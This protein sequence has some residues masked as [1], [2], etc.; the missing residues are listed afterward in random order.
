[1]ETPYSFDIAFLGLKDPSSAGRSRM[2][3]AMERL[4]GRSTSD[5]QEYLSKV[6]LTIFD[7]L[8]ADQA[9]L[10]I[11]ALDEAGAVCEIR[12]KEESARAV[13]DTPSGGMVQCPSCGFVQQ[14]G[15][16]ECSSCGV[17]FSKMEKDEVRKM[18][19]NQVLEEAQHRAEQIRQEWDD[20]AKQIVESR[21]LPEADFKA[22]NMVLTQEEIPFLLLE[23]AEGPLLMT[24]RQI[25]ALIEGSFAYLPYEIIKDVDYGGG[26]VGKKGH[27]RLVLHFHSPIMVK[28]KNVKSLTWQ[29]TADAATNKETIM[30][31]AFARSFMCGS[32]GER[33]LDFRN[34]KGETR[35]RCM[36]C[37]TDHSIDLRHHTI[38]PDEVEMRNGK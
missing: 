30:D 3:L 35:G 27:T 28:N 23:A 1:M 11:N 29:L 17:I 8:P 6:G 16:D 31:W 13:G 26:L 32:C 21:P 4:T 24:S 15:I 10:I 25:L 22:F 36:H 34:E 33:D 14:A 18:Q 20:R 19:S 37:A 9:K 38:T 5:C 2:V 7:S 12:P